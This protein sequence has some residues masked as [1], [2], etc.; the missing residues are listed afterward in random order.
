MRSMK[1][2]REAAQLI[3]DQNEKEMA[4]QAAFDSWLLSIEPDLEKKIIEAIVLNEPS[5]FYVTPKVSFDKRL[6]RFLCGMGYDC[7]N[8]VEDVSGV[9]IILKAVK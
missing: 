5:L 8:D 1:H 4:T 2:L 3:I 7:Y 9:T 6:T